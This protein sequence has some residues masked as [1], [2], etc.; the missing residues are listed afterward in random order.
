MNIPKGATHK[1]ADKRCISTG[2]VQYYRFD[3][4][5]WAFWTETA[6]PNRWAECGGPCVAVTPVGQ[7][8]QREQTRQAIIDLAEKKCG[9]YGDSFRQ[10]ATVLATEGYRKFEIVEED[11]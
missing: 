1:A 3:G 9:L 10:L 5:K 4:I 8:V 11:V 6:G 7:E 2:G